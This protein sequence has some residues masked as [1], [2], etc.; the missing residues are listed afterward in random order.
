MLELMLL[1]VR[2]LVNHKKGELSLGSNAGSPL[3]YEKR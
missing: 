3:R 2:P 1:L